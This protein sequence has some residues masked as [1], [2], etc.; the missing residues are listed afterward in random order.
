MSVKPAADVASPPSK[1]QSR[2]NLEMLTSGEHI[3]PSSSVLPL[4]RQAPSGQPDPG[5]PRVITVAPVHK[6]VLDHDIIEVDV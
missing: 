6:E 4:Q 5:R 2:S 1:K 3:L